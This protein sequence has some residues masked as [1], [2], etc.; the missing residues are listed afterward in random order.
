MGNRKAHRVSLVLLGA[1][2]LLAP[3][4][5]ARAQDPC[6]APGEA[7]RLA[8]LADA[9]AAFDPSG[10][11]R[12]S[13]RAVDEAESVLADRG[14]GLLDGCDALSRS[15]RRLE[16]LSGAPF[17][18]AAAHAFSDLFLDY[19]AER[20]ILEPALLPLDDRRAESIRRRLDS[21]DD[22]AALHA[23]A[24]EFGKGAALLLRAV[25]LIDRTL[26][27]PVPVF[28]GPFRV[29]STSLDGL[30]GVALNAPL[31]IRFSSRVEPASVRA[32]TIQ[33][34]HGP[35]FAQQVQGDFEVDGPVATFRPRLP[36]L[37][38]LSDGGFQPGT[39]YQLTIPGLPVSSTVRSRTGDPVSKSHVA[40]FL[41]TLDPSGYYG[42]EYFLDQAPQRVICTDPADVLPA[43]PWSGP[44]G[45]LEV[46]ATTPIVLQ[47]TRVP[48]LPG[49]VTGDDVVL[50]MTEFRGAPAM[51]RVPGDVVLVQSSRSVRLE[52]VPRVRLP[53]RSR[54]VL[55]VSDRVLDLTGSVPLAAHPGRDAIHAQ[56]VA[57][58][59]ADPAAP[60]AILLRD[61]PL[62]IDPRTFLV[63]TTRDEPEEVLSRT[64]EF[65][66]ADVDVDGGNGNDA[67][68]TTASFDAA[69]PGSVTAVLT[70]AGGDGSNGDLRPT[71]NTTLD[72]DSPLAPDG[73]FQFRSVLIPAGVT[74]T[75][76][77]SRPAVLRC[78][79]DATIDGVI[80]LAGG[81]G[82]AAETQLNASLPV[83]AGGAAG[84]GGGRG[85]DSSTSA[86]YGLPGGSGGDASGGGT[87]G[88]GGYE[89]SG[90][91]MYSFA[92]GGA[93][94]G[95]AASGT[96][97]GPGSYPTPGSGWNG[98]GGSAGL[99]GGTPPNSA[100]TNGGRQFTAA[101]GAGG[102]AGGNNH[103]TPYGHRTSGAG[104]GGG[105]GALL[106]TAAGSI[107][108]SGRIEAQGGTGGSAV[109][110]NS[111][112]GGSPGGGGAG[113]SIVLFSQAGLDVAGAVLNA[114]GGPGGSTAGA[115]Y[116]G[117]AGSGSDGFLR[118]EDADGAIA[119][120]G[121]ASAAPAAGQGTF[122]PASSAAD[123]P[124]VFASTW[125]SLG[126]FGPDILPFQPSDFAGVEVPGCDVAWE[127]QA[128]REDPLRPG[129]PDTG[130]INPVTGASSDPARA[131]GWNL[132]ADTAGGIRDLSAAIGGRG[133]EHFRLRVTFTL[134]DGLRAA[135]VKPG[136]D[137]F[138][139]RYRYQQ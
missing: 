76:R 108:V 75:V 26:H 134:G 14:V 90:A 29:V 100:I 102:G 77:G 44:A 5:T 59:A 135:D 64:L 69:V 48:L 18:G 78:R 7:D 33:I 53:D 40:Y 61:H 6:V 8:A 81:G 91:S 80:A 3:A 89:T 73:V 27:P 55:Q 11:P 113:G 36:V 116:I 88:G 105:G 104:G 118:L 70:M 63:F 51:R 87:G 60:L 19:V 72:T 37:A 21:L 82:D 112:F 103:Y 98:A 2:A 79:G 66:G 106:L 47:L 4:S 35:G 9:V 138:R 49:T 124:S 122:D 68:R 12:R 32:D 41:T 39:P 62:E 132:L 121:L 117:T 38:D 22:S 115:F 119:G 114:L 42:P 131:S 96:A 83:R 31:V 52:F 30:T 46:P 97:G 28:G 110:A 13:R 50:T 56:A 129:K 101:G 16:R 10:L 137:R 126:A 136:V 58:R 34:R 128:A 93:G 20:A 95:H 133:F 99:A 24:G 71:V 130:T 107:R 45:A 74:V 17:A 127:F 23:G 123:A 86:L 57:A 65:D 111:Y 125:I 25:R 1:L 43:A 92:G 109:S 94:G 67:A 54:F 85:G 139:V 120:L 15:S 84:A